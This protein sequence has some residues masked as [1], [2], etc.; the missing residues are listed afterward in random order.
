[1]K[2]SAP[3]SS[4]HQLWR[5]VTGRSGIPLLSFGEMI[6]PLVAAPSK[7]SSLLSQSAVN[8]NLSLLLSSLLMRVSAHLQELTDIEIEVESS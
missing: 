6:K 3:S 5:N 1:M 8:H 4:M 7:Y 2:D